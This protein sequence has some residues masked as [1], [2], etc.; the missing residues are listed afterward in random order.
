MFL[1]MYVW[2]SHQKLLDED[3]FEEMVLSGKT[4]IDVRCACA[5]SVGSQLR[6]WLA[7]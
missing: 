1:G 4:K 7:R 2:S 5:T 6:G 3:L